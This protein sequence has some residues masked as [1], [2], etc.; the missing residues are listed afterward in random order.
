MSV[1]TG[2]KRLL[3]WKERTMS[4]PIQNR[5]STQATSMGLDLPKRGRRS[6]KRD[7]P[8]NETA[9][10]QPSGW[11]ARC[12]DADF[13]SPLIPKVQQ[14]DDRRFAK[15][16]RKSSRIST[17]DAFW[18]KKNAVSDILTTRQNNLGSKKSHRWLAFDA[19]KTTIIHLEMYS[20]LIS[21]TSF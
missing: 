8:K 19:D 9:M 15:N 2:V 11:M 6:E 5:Y 12:L 14:K 17:D 13:L 18:F 21:D 10:N 1:D 16:V 20:E 4:F 7:V 3:G